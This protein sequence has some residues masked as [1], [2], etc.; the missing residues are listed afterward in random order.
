MAELEPKQIGFI[1]AHGTGTPLNDAAEVAGIEHAFGGHAPHCPIHSG[2]AS[3][4]HCLGAAGALE[5]IATVMSL[6]A[7]L[8]PA[9]AGLVQSDFE[10]RVDCVVGAPR[11]VDANFAISNSF[12]FG[13]NNA[14]LVF[15]SPGVCV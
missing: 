1:N 8:V 4:G 7:G 3:T 11:A 13:G 2:K 10:G 9:T 5:A 6:R 12:G 15:A 14:A